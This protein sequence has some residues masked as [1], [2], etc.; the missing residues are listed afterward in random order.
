MNT[1][2]QYTVIER[3]RMGDHV[4]VGNN[5]TI[6]E[7]AVIG[8]GVVIGHNCVLEKYVKIGRDTHIMPQCHLTVGCVIEGECFLGVGII[9]GDDKNLCYLR[10]TDYAS[11][12]PVIR[13]AAR[14]GSGA[15]ILPGVVIGENAVVGMGAIVTKNVPAGEIWCGVP[16]KKIKN[17]AKEDII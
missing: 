8:D 4:F 10:S 1:I 17:V 3:I 12:P 16:A 15:I 5:V 2:G 13:R 6:R 14:I 9:T 7:G 11:T